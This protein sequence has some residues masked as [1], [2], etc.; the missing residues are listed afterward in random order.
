MSLTRRNLI[1]LLI[2]TGILIFFAV[3]LFTRPALLTLFDYSQ[4]GQIGDTIG[5]IASPIIGILGAMLV[6]LSFQEQ[7]DAY[8][9]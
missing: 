6:Y 5:G 7:I 4:T 2:G 9:C 8:S 3:L 1:I